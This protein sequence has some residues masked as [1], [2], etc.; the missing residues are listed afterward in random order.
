MLGGQNIQQIRHSRKDIS[1]WK[2][3]LECIKKR[4]QKGNIKMIFRDMEFRIRKSKYIQQDSP[5]ETIKQLGKRQN[6]KR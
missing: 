3:Y 4:F 1:E 5:K 6:L 2:N